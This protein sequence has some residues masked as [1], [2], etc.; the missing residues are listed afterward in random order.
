MSHPSMDFPVIFEQKEIPFELYI[1]LPLSTSLIMPRPFHV[2]SAGMKTNR[3]SHDIP[4][5]RLFSR[6]PTMAKCKCGESRVSLTRCYRT[7]AH[8]C[9]SARAERSCCTQ[10]RGRRFA[11]RNMPLWSRYTC[12]V[13]RLVSSPARRWT[14]ADSS[15]GMEIPT[16]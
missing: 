6:R 8:F 12:V 11:S 14:R 5:A 2:T 10:S 9:P 4:L 1:H 16:S 3:D 13:R 15:L 7:Q